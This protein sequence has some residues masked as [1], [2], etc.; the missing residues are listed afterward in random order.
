MLEPSTPGRT[1]RRH[2]ALVEAA[3]EHHAERP[4]DGD[5]GDRH[6]REVERAPRRR[7]GGEPAG[8]DGAAGEP[9]RQAHGEGDRQADDDVGGDDGGPDRARG[10]ARR[11]QSVTMLRAAATPSPK[12][13]VQAGPSHQRADAQARLVRARPPRQ[14]QHLAGVH[15]GESTEPA[16]PSG[17][18]MRRIDDGAD[19]WRA[20]RAADPSGVAPMPRARS[21]HYLIRDRAPSLPPQ[22]MTSRCAAILPVR[23]RTAC[24]RRSRRPRA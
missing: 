23:G 9:E 21:P 15:G 1:E 4:A 3:G 5:A 19:R 22:V 6:E 18:A 8:A 20:V 10:V 14:A 24:R 17:R 12:A 2:E 7:P 13:S 11:G 16:S